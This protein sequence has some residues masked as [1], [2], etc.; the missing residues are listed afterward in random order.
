MTEYILDNRA[1][2]AGNRFGALSELFDA[3]TDR[4][5]AA[6]GIEP[7]WRCW[8]VGAGGPAV[9]RLLAERG[10]QVLATDIDIRWMGD[11]DGVEVRQH[12]VARDELPGTGF[13]LIHARLVLTHIPEREDVLSRLISALRPGGWLFIEDVDAALH[14]AAFLDPQEEVHHLGNRM[15]E[16]FVKLLDHRGVDTAWGRK[17]PRVLR[18][19]GLADIVCDGRLTLEYPGGA[20]LER[21]N[22]E[23]VR[24]G[25]IAQGFATAEEIDTYLAALDRITPAGPPLISA[26]GRRP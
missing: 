7:G 2:Q 11:L 8:E 14:P 4:H 26:Y 22:I 9:P 13:D 24:D 18:E 1:A 15:R 25:L 6:I 19:R 16:A 12:D 23:Q 10:G 3:T 17:L 21:A 5:F 20:E